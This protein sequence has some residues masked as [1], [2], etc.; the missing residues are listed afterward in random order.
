LRAALRLAGKEIRRLTFGK[1]D[2]KVLP[3]LRRT[4]RKSRVVAKK[5]QV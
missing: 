2:N 5:C 3:I 1:K 4:L